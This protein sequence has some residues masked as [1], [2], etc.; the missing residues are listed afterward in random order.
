MRDGDAAGGYGRVTV[1]R[2]RVLA[3]AA[4]VALVV[5]CP[6]LLLN[7]ARFAELAW[8]SAS[9]PGQL[10]YGEG[11]VWQ[12]AVLMLTPRM[13]GNVQNY[14]FL[15]FHYPP[16]YHL[17]VDALASSGVS[18]LAAGRVLSSLALAC[19]S[20]CA[21]LFV[22]ETAARS[23]GRRDISGQARLIAAVVTGL[24]VFSLDPMRYWGRLARVD[25]L[26]SALEYLGLYLGLRALRHGGS[27]VPVGLVFVA[28]M[29]TK[30][31][32]IAGAMAI[33]LAALI[34]GRRDIWRAGLIAGGTGAA[35]F[36]ALT[37][38]T[39]G[40][41]F[42]HLVL[43]NVNRFNLSDVFVRLA[44]VGDENLHLAYVAIPLIALLILASRALMGGLK[45]LPMGGLIIL[46]VALVNIASLIGLGKSGAAAN[47]IIP[48]VCASAI[49]SGLLIAE[50]ARQ[51]G[52]P[53]GQP[54]WFLAITAALIA[55]TAVLPAS[56]ENRLVSPAFRRD[57][58]TLIGM[59]RDAPKPVLSDDMVLLM[60]A[61]KPIPW[62]PLIIT[63]LAATGVFDERKVIDMIAAHAFSFVVIN[64]TLENGFFSRDVNAALAAAYPRE[65]MIGKKHLLLPREP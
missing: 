12:Q 33:G 24:L 32:A 28:A 37:W 4:A 56:G 52:R 6:L 15:V 47:Y 36:L 54:I 20:L 62:E 9:F 2:A 46:I 11:I 34:H 39:G 48:L 53:N 51:V 23:D 61:G 44:A 21:G 30:Q 31:T 18:W 22:W 35:L 65:T 59:I 14:P 5:L 38:I 16:L 26:A 3:G 40:G 27:L 64:D 1:T 58:M 43:Y 10:D 25:L 45:A 8:L 42:R 17:T 57:T 49:L 19:V 50:T 7:V 13:Y 55:Q 29:F 63:E 41:F 60:Q